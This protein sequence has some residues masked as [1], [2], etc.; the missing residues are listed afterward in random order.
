[1]WG[2]NVNAAK[3]AIYVAGRDKQNLITADAELGIPV[4][5]LPIRYLGLPL[6][7]KLMTALDYA[8]LI[9]QI[10]KRFMLGSGFA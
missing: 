6:T 3:S 1:M 9:D 10:R 8:P 7:T 5:T 2:P 4:D